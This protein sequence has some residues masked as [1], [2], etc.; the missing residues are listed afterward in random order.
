MSHRRQALAAALG[1]LVIGHGSVVANAEQRVAD[2]QIEGELPIDD[3]ESLLLTKE[4]PWYA[5]WR[6]HPPY[7]PTTLEAD[8]LRLRRA[9]E[10]AGY[11]GAEIHS[12]VR[13]AGEPA[14]RS[15][16]EAEA[17]L[18]D[19]EIQLDPGRPTHVRTLTILGGDPTPPEDGWRLAEG[20]VF[21]QEAYEETEVQIGDAYLRKSRAWTS[22]GREARVHAAEHVADVTYEV[23]PGPETVFGKTQV[24]GAV[25]FDEEL[26]RREIRWEPGDAF[27]PSLL[28]ET[29]AAIRGLG[30]YESV[31]I[32]PDSDAQGQRVVPMIIEVEEGPPR[33]IAIGLTY[34]TA[35]QI[36]GSV[37]WR[38]NDWMGGGR[39]L[40]ARL[41]ITNFD[42][43]ADLL[44]VQPY[45][46]DDDSTGSILFRQTLDDEPTY[47][48]LATELAPRL[49]YQI[50]PT[51][52]GFVS[53]R[54]QYASL[55]NVDES[56]DVALGGVKDSGFVS[57]PR[58]GVV[59]NTTL[60]PLDARQG[61]IASLAFDYSGVPFG[62]GYRFWKLVGEIKRYVTLPR[63]FV[64]AG[65]LKA[66]L[67]DAI[68]E[69]QALPLF[70]RFYAGGER[71]VRGYARRKL[72]PLTDTGQPI[73]GLSLF[74]GSI[75][76]RRM[77][78]G[79]VGAVAFLD[80]GQVSPRAFDLP[81]A[82]VDF[83]AGP[84][85]TVDTPVGPLRL[86]V[87]FPFDPPP[88]ESS[89]QIHLSIGHFF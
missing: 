13:P 52:D 74:E 65:R 42:S 6:D 12:E 22:I 14:G 36:G 88:G 35:D 1:F 82:D 47:E 7:E 2:L 5:P 43:Y 27:D 26:I 79:P 69:E 81:V 60:D 34:N 4:R 21:R 46:F 24:E 31:R 54:G 18:V 53:F 25:D 63:D 59:W 41:Q 78:Y 29:R 83:S 38:H 58:V 76:L 77:V 50:T 72:G 30:L 10:R 33:E 17:G 28:I 89:W 66:G 57:G 49:D 64:L 20:D 44:L 85:I 51:L 8:L 61:G 9:L 37:A 56:V 70:E 11:Y 32:R 3:A 62:A 86:D 68:G 39:Q 87:G 75:E 55:R 19:I 48:L 40:S 80:F 16:D 84:G 15:D 71:S 23:E 45:L 73:G 67:T